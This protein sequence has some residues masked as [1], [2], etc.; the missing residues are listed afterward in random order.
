MNFR[1]EVTVQRTARFIQGCGKFD[2]P[3]AAT[4][5]QE[6]ELDLTLPAEWSVL[7]I[8]GPSMSGKTSIA[9]H[10]F[11]GELVEQ[12][13]WPWPT[14]QCIL[15]GFPAGMSIDDICGLLS[16]VGFSSPPDWKKPYAA[17]SN[18]GKFRVDLARTLAERPQRTVIDEFGSLVHQQAR[19]VA[20]AAAAKAVRRRGGQLVAL[21][22]YPDAV[23]Y[24]EPDAVIDVRPGQKVTVDVTRGLLRRPPI[25]LKIVRVH[26]SAWERFRH[27]HYLSHDL[28]RAAKCFVGLVGSDEQ[29]W[30]PAAFTAVLPFPHAIKPGWREHRTVCLP[31]YQGIGIGNRMSETVASIFAATGKPYTSATS[32]PAMIRHRARSRV[33]KTIRK[34]GLGGVHNGNGRTGMRDTSATSRITA[35]FQYVGRVADAET[36]RQMT[37]AGTVKLRLKSRG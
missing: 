22:L 12:G 21:V 6:W 4:A 5:V 33:W 19:N 34:P 24:F 15:D 36:A 2:L 13:H 32:H 20:A 18:G 3:T 35:S 8:V 23:P 30:E 17:L 28:H 27:H 1:R 14:D 9:N 25:D 26:P 37:V 16:S 11:P 10:L 29:G 7:V 31:D